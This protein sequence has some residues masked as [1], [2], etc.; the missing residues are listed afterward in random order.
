MLTV[1]D[2]QKIGDLIDL[3]LDIKLKPIKK[4]IRY[5]KKTIDLVIK[6]YDEADVAISKRVAKIEEWVEQM[7][8]Q[9]MMY[10]NLT[11]IR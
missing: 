3:K 10:R 9:L 6:N 8:L 11:R 7:K 1:S 2:L 4:D 5:I